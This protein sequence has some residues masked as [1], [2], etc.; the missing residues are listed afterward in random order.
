[1]D[2]TQTA[3]GGNQIDGLRATARI[4]VELLLGKYEFES[5]FVQ[6][7]GHPNNSLEATLRK[8]QARSGTL[9]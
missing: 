3:V 4:L 8:A 5:V 1:V 7:L 9:W 2:S 6:V